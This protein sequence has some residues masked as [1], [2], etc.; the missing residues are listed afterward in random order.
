MWKSIGESCGIV[1]WS[2]RIQFVTPTENIK[3]VSS[4]RARVFGKRSQRV[5]S[6]LADGTQKNFFGIGSIMSQRLW[7]NEVFWYDSSFRREV[8]PILVCYSD[9][10]KIEGCIGERTIMLQWHHTRGFYQRLIGVRLILSWR[11]RVSSGCFRKTRGSLYS[12][13]LTSYCL[14]DM[15]WKDDFRQ[16]KVLSTKRLPDDWWL[17]RHI[18]GLSMKHH[19]VCERS[20]RLRW[21]MA[22]ANKEK[23]IVT[24]NETKGRLGEKDS[25]VSVTEYNRNMISRKHKDLW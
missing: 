8:S 7:V 11:S 25:C 16:N 4:V 24:M 17:Q 21:V 14:S 15:G 1:I 6:G 19:V 18:R 13:S 9:P 10:Q 3:V 20:S 5:T 23:A 12:I 22:K 2:W